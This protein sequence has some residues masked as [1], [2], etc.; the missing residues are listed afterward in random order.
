MFKLARA[1]A[2]CIEYQ[3]VRD[4]SDGEMEQM[5]N[6]QGRLGSELASRRKFEGWPRFPEKE[7]ESRALHLPPEKAT[8]GS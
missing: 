2:Y 7:Y 6:S 5:Q 4:E 3:M 8:R 1:A